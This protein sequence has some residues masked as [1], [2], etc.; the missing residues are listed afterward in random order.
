[1]GV[2]TNLAKKLENARKEHL[3]AAKALQE[4][5][6]EQAELA[7]LIVSQSEKYND[8]IQKK[9]GTN[10]ASIMKGIEK[11]EITKDSEHWKHM[12]EIG[13]KG[14][15]LMELKEKQLPL[16]NE[17]SKARKLVQTKIN[18]VV[19]AKSA[20]D[21]YVEKKETRVKDDPA[22]VAYKNAVK[23]AIS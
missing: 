22:W 2:R 16:D 12:E 9:L 17:V 23:K 7:A 10:Y 4:K 6:K 11:G 3:E 20:L 1:M 14:A 18:W 19:A 15:K 5:V 21:E 13:A 8:F